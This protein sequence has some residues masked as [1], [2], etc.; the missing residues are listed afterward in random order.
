MIRV[1]SWRINSQTFNRTSYLRW[2]LRAFVCSLF[3]IS[4]LGGFT[5]NYQS[6]KSGFTHFF[7]DETG[8][9]H[10]MLMDSVSVFGTDSIFTNHFTVRQLVDGRLNVPVAGWLGEKTIIKPTGEN[11]FFNAGGDTILIETQAQLNDTWNLF[12]L[13]PSSYLEATV[14]SVGTE[15]ILGSS[16]DIKTIS[17]QRKDYSGTLLNHPLN[18]K[19]IQLSNSLGIIQGLDFYL[20]PNDTTQIEIAGMENPTIGIHRL[21]PEEAYDFEVGDEFHYEY[22]KNANDGSSPHFEKR[23]E[24]VTSVNNDPNGRR[25]MF[26]VW[27]W[28]RRF[29]GQP[30]PLTLIEESIYINDSLILSEPWFSSPLTDA[31]PNS[32]EDL[33]TS[34]GYLHY[35][36]T[37]FHYFETSHIPA[38]TFQGSDNSHYEID[39]VGF[40]SSAI[41][42]GWD[43]STTTYG[44]G[45]G[46]TYWTHQ[47]GNGVDYLDE[48]EELTYFKKGTQEWGTPFTISEIMDVGNVQAEIN[49]T[50]YPNPIK[51][52]S[53]LQLEKQREQ[54][55]I[56]D[57]SGKLIRSV[58]NS[59]VVETNGLPSGI[60]L[61]KIK[62]DSSISTQKLVVTN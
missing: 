56:F 41:F 30:S 45:I 53:L 22:E 60:Y 46:R 12:K 61:V 25:I 55:E 57:L 50:L 5:Q 43:Y 26:D 15:T 2:M 7:L 21:T 37:E 35:T 3:L 48:T 31:M 17:L 44:N 33:D 6:V 11:L 9:D 13:N 28:V 51:S 32:A 8:E 58:K 62:T 1:E 39:S 59:T 23:I 54:V 20:F 38:L 27:M 16:V 52:G 18:G 42:S 40:W 36:P 24:R 49:Y 4:S 29:D 19:T 34:S 47:I 10:G 14:L